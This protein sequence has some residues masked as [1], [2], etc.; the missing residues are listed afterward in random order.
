MIRLILFAV[1]FITFSRDVAGQIL[2]PVKWKYTVSKISPEVYK[3][4]FKAT[5]QQ[6]WHVYSQ[7]QPKKS[8][9]QPLQLTLNKNAS[10]VVE[11]KPREIGKLIKSVDR[12]I[13]IE[14]YHYLNNLELVQVIRVKNMKK[15]RL[16]GLLTYQTCNNEKCL[17]ADDFEFSIPLN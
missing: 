16:T 2:T 9:A 7:V 11:G 15:S 13:N 1:L 5:I 6:G 12:T 17:P 4:S 14:D 3:I 8:I 10:I